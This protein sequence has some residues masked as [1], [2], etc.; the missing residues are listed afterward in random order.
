MKYFMTGLGFI[1][2]LVVGLI[3]YGAYLNHRSENQISERLEKQ[4]VPLSGEIAKYREIKPIFQLETIRLTSNELTDA[5]ALVGGRITNVLVQKND[6]VRAGQVIAVIFAPELETRIKQADSAI[7]KA[8][9]ELSEARN[10]FGRYERLK[11]KDATSLSQ[12]DHAQTSYLAAQ[13]ALSAA[14]S[15]KEELL[16][17]VAE[18]EVRAPVDGEVIIVYRPKGAYVTQGTSLA[19]IGDFKK[20]RFAMPIDGAMA[21]NL[22][23]GNEVGLIFDRESFDKV[24]D[25]KYASGNLGKKEE[26]TAVVKEI[27]PDLSK[28][29][30]IRRVEYEVDN[31]AGLLEQKTYTDIRL[32]SKVAHR[33]LT[34][35]LTAMTDSSCTSVFVFKEDETLELREVETGLRDG[36]YIEI[37][38]G[39]NEGEVVVTSVI[40]GLTN[41]TKATLSISETRSDADGR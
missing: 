38:S 2:F 27:N 30:A 7:L 4:R 31:S 22:R 24:Y 26:F 14:V 39:L 18:Q 3:S 34:V 5:M 15:K 8:E 16:V 35:P 33:C 13:S 1:F 41:G 28:P 29:A 17:Q 9:A 19:L 32:V 21:N 6:H 36:Q 25:T 40:K 20:L 23:E 10:N 11:A 37:L 12:Y